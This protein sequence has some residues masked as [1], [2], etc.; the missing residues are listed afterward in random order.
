[1]LDARTSEGSGRSSSSIG[2]GTGDEDWGVRLGYAA[3]R[4]DTSAL[5]GAVQSRFG[6]E[7]ETRMTAISLEASRNVGT[8]TFSGLMEAAE[9]ELDGL[10][11]SGLWTSSWTLNAQHPFA[12]GTLR[13]S[14][15]QPRRAE[16]GALSFKAP[17]EV[18]RSGRIV[19]ESRTAG[20][21]PSGRELDFELAWMAPLGDL[22]TFEAA[23]ALATQPNHIADAQDEA[24][25]WLSLRH[26]W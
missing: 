10:N 22:T 21:T 24:A 23:L 18:T 4:D 3:M 6:G 14:A 20:L 17:I 25:F 8:W 12:G 19:Y 9:P 16:G 2:I 11:V 7:D 15:A 26:A 5:G 13:L 1:M